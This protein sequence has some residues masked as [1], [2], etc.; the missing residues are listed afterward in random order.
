MKIRVLPWTNA[1]R[2]YTAFLGDLRV[3]TAKHIR[4]DYWA[5]WCKY[6]KAP[7]SVVKREANAVSTLESM[8]TLYYIH[9]HEPPK[10]LTGTT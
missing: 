10:L 5:C 1:A 6:S 3:G 2:G 9:R 7:P 8:C 4:D